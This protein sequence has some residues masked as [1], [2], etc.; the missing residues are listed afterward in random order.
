MSRP[1]H[2][3]IVEG[4]FYDDIADEMAKGA[5]EA[6]DAAGVTHD[7]LA[8][9]GALEIPCVIANALAAEQHYDG[10]VALGC[11][12]RGE[13]SHYDYVCGESAR[14]L[15]DLTVQKGIAIGNGILTVEDRDQAWARAARDQKNKGGAVARACLRVMDIKADFG[16]PTP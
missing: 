5:E 6:L 9:D 8:V 3:L 2:V 10:F 13:T 11:V 15:M 7:R 16:L 12:I 1:R 14:G 4:R